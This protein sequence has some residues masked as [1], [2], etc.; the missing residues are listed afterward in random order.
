MPETVKGPK[1]GGT[2]MAGPKCPASVQEK[3]VGE[4]H[5]LFL[6]NEWTYT[7]EVVVLIFTVISLENNEMGSE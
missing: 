4:S 5:T 1:W 3:S 7:A 2:E 6:D